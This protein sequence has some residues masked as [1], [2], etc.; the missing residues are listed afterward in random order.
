MSNKRVLITAALPYA[1][2]ML[3]FG[4][5]AGAYLPADAAARFARLCGKEV[6]FLCGSDEHGVAITLSAE[7]AGRTPQAHVDL[8]HGLLQ[9]FFRTLQIS[10]DHYS[11]TT[12]KGHA[13]VV[14]RFFL[15]LLE[16][17]YIEERITDQLYSEADGRFLADRYVVGECPRCGFLEARGDEC[18]QCGASYEATDLKSPRSKVTGAGLTL[19]PTRHWFLRFDLFKEQ[20]QHFLNARSW[21]PNVLHFA[22]H[23][24]DDLRP[25]AITRDLEWGVPVPLPG[26]EGKVFYVW[27]GAPIGYISAAMEWAEQRGE[28]EAWR[29]YWLEEST[30]YLQFMGKDNIPFHAIFFPAMIFGQSLP[31]KQVDHLSANEFYNLEG[32]QFSKSEGWTIDLAAFF[33]RFTPD[34]I[35]YTL[36][37][38]APESADSDFSWR[39]FQMRCNSELVGKWGNFAHRVLTFIQAQCAGKA[40]RLSELEDVDSEFLAKISALVAEAKESYGEQ[41]LRRASQLMMELAQVGNGYF[42]A[43]QPWKDA[44]QEGARPR[45]ERTLA[46]SLEALKAMAL[47][48]FPIIPE[49][50]ERLWRLLGQRGVLAQGRWEEIAEGGLEAGV[51]PVP[52]PLF[53]RVEEEVIVEEQQ[54]LAQVLEQKRQSPVKET[55]TYETFEKLDLRVGVVTQAEPIPKSKKLLRLEVDLGFERRTV[56]SGISQHYLPEQLVGK[57][58]VVVANLAPTKIMGVESRGMILAGESNGVLELLS[59]E[60][61]PP[62]STIS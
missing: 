43:K 44:K 6:L 2:G 7:Q 23:Y 28:P 46:A 13:P 62:G 58:V 3:H 1:N 19:R 35:R 48:A 51:L 40:P 33:R 55:I 50:A 29:R 53:Q 41:R 11:R 57:R 9:E 54:K 27:F 22:R 49:S 8:Y 14:Q 5:I 30:E 34:Q 59:P 38:N 52:E 32:R 12:W 56:V 37:A 36:A 31:Y 21:R 15:D 20:L 10:F 26:A 61:L 25:R 24:V 39:D 42:D 16:R 4:H 18:P 47:V 17:G 45:M 60:Q